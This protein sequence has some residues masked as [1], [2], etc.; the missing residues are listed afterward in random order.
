MKH[1][2]WLCVCY[3]FILACLFFYQERRILEET[4]T[5]LNPTGLLNQ[6][7]GQTPASPGP[8]NNMRDTP[9]QQNGQ[10]IATGN[11]GQHASK[12]HFFQ[13][14]LKAGALTDMT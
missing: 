8:E 4:V 2:S 10:K 12:L 14:E 5:P 3:F 6:Q 9:L 13:G 1:I 11:E 7:S